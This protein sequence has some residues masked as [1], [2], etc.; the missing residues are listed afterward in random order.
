[1]F[2]PKC[3]TEEMAR[4]TYNGVEIDRCPVCKGMYFD[5]GEGEDLRRVSPAAAVA[6]FICFIFT[7]L[8]GVWPQPL[9][10]WAKAAVVPLLPILP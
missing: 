2:C 8:L 1:M 4:E 9:V 5:K 3:R 10:A 7:V 6:L